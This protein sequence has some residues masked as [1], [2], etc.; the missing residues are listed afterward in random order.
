MGRP[1]ILK[2]DILSEY[3]QRGTRTAQQQLDA[4]AGKATIVA[5]AL[6]AGGLAAVKA[7]STQEQAYGAL[8]AV[9]GDGA[10]ELEAWAE[11]QAAIGLS[12]GEAAQ[13]AA[14]LGS[15]LKGA[16]MDTATAADQAQRLTELGA[17]LAATYG[18]TTA[19]A[20][21]ALAATMRGEYDP[22]ERFGVAIKQSDVNARLA[23]QGQSD[24][25]GE[26]RKLA[27]QQARLALLTET[28][29]DAQGQAAR[30]SGTW[31]SQLEQ[32]RATAT[33][34]AATFGSELLPAG[35]GVLG[36]LRRGAEWAGRNTTA[37]RVMV[38]AVA[39]LT[40]AILV[41]NGAMRAYAAAAAA[42][43]TVTLAVAAAQRI[44]AAA[45]IATRA[46]NVAMTAAALAYAAA[47]NVVRVAT[48]AWTAAQKLL[49]IALR[50]NPI[51]LVVTAIGLLVGALVTAYNKSDSFRT[52]VDKVAGVLSGA[53]RGAIDAVSGAVQT[54]VGW[55]QT[56]IGWV[57]DLIAW[58]G[59]IKAPS[60][61]LP[62]RSGRAAPSS[63][64]APTMSRAGYAPA[65][66]YSTSTA[67][68][69]ITVNVT[70]ALDPDAVARQIGRVLATHA[71]HTGRPVPAWT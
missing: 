63:A 27:E 33:N 7:A 43:R 59:R 31:A 64:T 65:A 37:V 24:L 52:I 50:A 16:G 14:Y 46:T 8:A 20:V 70:G 12:A 10:G 40:A 58:L 68:A 17:D 56:A 62:G 3:D 45:N 23:A 30:E 49:N 44:A 51:G 66:G 41:V 29:T 36:F 35:T 5:A 13:S 47:S 48:V 57:E 2:I 4:L 21:A 60:F 22:I 38:G 26:A 15:M 71:R 61:S 1:A 54:L 25:T 69:G 42:V 39:A 19:D 28:T 11:Q 67:G 55:L 53:V 32:L 9:F 6:A 18:G 34:T